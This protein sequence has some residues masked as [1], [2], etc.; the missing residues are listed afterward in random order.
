M[1]HKEELEKAYEK[2]IIVG[3]EKCLIEL[4]K[5][6]DERKAQLKQFNEDAEYEAKK[7]AG[8]FKKVKKQ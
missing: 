5:F 7:K 1:S 8:I 6:I 4:S 2:G 3:W